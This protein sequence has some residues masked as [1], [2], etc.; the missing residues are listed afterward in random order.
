ME[1][2]ASFF[3]DHGVTLLLL[4]TVLVLMAYIRGR[5]TNLA[6]AKRLAALVEGILQPL[7]KEY[8]WIGGLTGFKAVLSLEG[9][10]EA[11][12]TLVM[13]PRQSLIYL[14]ISMLIFGGDKLFLV[15]KDL[16]GLPA[17]CH[18]LS[19]RYRKSPQAWLPAHDDFCRVVPV[20]QGGLT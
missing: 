8:T 17:E 20:K 5:R 2:I 9:G 11:R 18:A 4:F 12:V 16:E 10:L 15:F 19:A 1:S 7:D 6:M 13:K 14:P 3:R